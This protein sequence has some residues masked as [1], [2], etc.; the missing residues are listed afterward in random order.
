M[1]SRQPV[2][3]DDAAAIETSFP[4]FADKMN[5]LGA[6]ISGPLA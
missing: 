1:A 6:Q 2:E 4:G 3:I 5:G